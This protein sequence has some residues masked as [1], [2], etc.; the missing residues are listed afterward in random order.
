MPERAANDNEE[1]DEGLLQCPVRLFQEEEEAFP[2]ENGDAAFLLTLKEGKSGCFTDEGTPQTESKSP[3]TVTTR[4]LFAFGFGDGKNDVKSSSSRVF[5]FKDDDDDE[6]KAPCLVA[7][8]GSPSPLS[9]R[10]WTNVTGGE[11]S[12]FW[13]DA[14]DNDD[15]D[16]LIPVT[17]DRLTPRGSSFFPPLPQMPTVSFNGWTTKLEPSHTPEI[18]SVALTVAETP[19]LPTPPLAS[20]LPLLSR[21]RMLHRCSPPFRMNRSAPAPPRSNP[22]SARAP[23]H[24]RPLQS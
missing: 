16:V 18:L 12:E 7:G 1:E 24:H 6:G 21:L 10:S 17:I 5:V 22:P 19:P 9:P 20:L 3:L 11:V 14:V 13:T 4:W 23:S 8:I 2:Y 15:E